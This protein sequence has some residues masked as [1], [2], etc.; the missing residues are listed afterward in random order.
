MNVG[1]TESSTRITHAYSDTALS[2][3]NRE[4]EWITE[5]CIVLKMQSETAEFLCFTQN[6]LPPFDI[7]FILMYCDKLLSAF[8]YAGFRGR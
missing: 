7:P 5:K 8:N 3:C 2:H 6:I 4:M 1:F